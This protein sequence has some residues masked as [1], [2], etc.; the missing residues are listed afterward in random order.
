MFDL[1]APILFA[2]LFW[3]L[4]TGAILWL[5]RL[6]AATFKWTAAG[7]T[8]LLVAA[9]AATYL[10]RDNVGL[11]AAYGGFAA[12]ILSWAWH[13]VMFLLGYISGPNKRPCPPNLSNWPRFVAST[14]TLIYHE[15]AIAVH[16]GLIVLITAGA[17]NK[18]AAWTFLLLW[19]MRLSAKLIVFFGAPNI[20]D[21]FL[22]AH[23]GYLKTY[24]AKRSISMFTP[25]AMSVVTVATALVLYQASLA[26]LGSF[27]SAAWL[28]VGAL[29]TLAV[30]EHLA[31]L[32]P[33]PDQAL[34]GWAVKKSPMNS[35]K[36]RKSDG[37]GNGF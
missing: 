1:A 20:A 8:L 35:T 34:W 4:S 19:G 11:A 26:P 16:A 17:A 29:A 14:R 21:G 31:L 22:P 3:W 28:L 9:S 32:M 2:L 25:I 7:T 13:E 30:F 10:L 15:L 27:H 36:I 6:P 37:G 5:V 12:G 24:F 23:L 33:L 18:I